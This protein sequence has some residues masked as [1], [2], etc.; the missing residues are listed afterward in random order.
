MLRILSVVL[1]LLGLSLA[2]NLEYDFEPQ[3][4]AQFRKAV[5]T[6]KIGSV[7]SFLIR[8]ELPED[9]IKKGFTIACSNRKLKMLEVFLAKSPLT[10]SES[11]QIMIKSLPPGSFREISSIVLLIFSHEEVIAAISQ[12]YMEHPQA[13]ETLLR[14]MITF[15]NITQSFYLLVDRPGV[16]EWLLNINFFKYKSLCNCSI[17][18]AI[19]KLMFQGEYK[20]L[21]AKILK[22]LASRIAVS[23]FTDEEYQEIGLRLVRRSDTESLRYLLQFQQD[24]QYTDALF[25]MALD[26][27][28]RNVIQ[29]FLDLDAID[30]SQWSEVIHKMM[31]GFDGFWLKG[32]LTSFRRHP[33]TTPLLFKDLV[34]F[35]IVRCINIRQVL[36]LCQLCLDQATDITVAS[37]IIA[38]YRYLC[39]CN[40]L[41]VDVKFH[42]LYSMIRLFLRDN[43]KI[44]YNY[45]DMDH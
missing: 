37:K 32:Y 28:S 44:A 15:E 3:F 20:G 16:L 17:A 8:G 11:L 42:I 9:I 25:L 35:S 43:S 6:N 14:K 13:C 41:I 34:S 30:P 2:S 36:L 26:M 10:H 29:T 19:E 39:K 1:L 33:N 21:V 7:Q 27:A 24:I 22:V 23:P 40:E 4:Y 12:N 31:Y 45:I 5:E 38:A 18:Y